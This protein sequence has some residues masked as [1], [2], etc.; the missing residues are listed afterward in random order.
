MPFVVSQGVLASGHQYQNATI[1]VGGSVM[2]ADGLA[3]DHAAIWRTQPQVRTV[4]SFLARNIA[5]L[6]IHVYQ[7]LSDV[8]RVRL[9]DHPVGRRR[10]HQPH[11]VGGPHLRS[12]R[13]DR[14]LA[15]FYPPPR[16]P[17]L[18]D[19]RA[20]SER[21]M[22]GYRLSDRQWKTIV[23][24]LSV[25]KRVRLVAGQIAALTRATLASA[26]S[27]AR[28]TVEEGTRPKGRAYA[29]VA[30]DDPFGEYSTEHVPRHRA[31]SRAVGDKQ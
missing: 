1:P 5:Q 18:R 14:P 22:P 8:D 19:R 17:P 4:V 11:R 30:H 15:A 31:L 28:V 6:G 25:R 3:Q 24:A 12:R 7:R 20:E 29:R 27:E 2:L 23:Q 16:G 10:A 13:P 26:G 9:S 21:M